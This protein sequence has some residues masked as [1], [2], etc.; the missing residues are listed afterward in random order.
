[1]FEGELNLMDWVLI[2]MGLVVLIL[3]GYNGMTWRNPQDER[4]F[5]G[6]E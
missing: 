6:G 4:D 5:E 2:A 3:L 1:M